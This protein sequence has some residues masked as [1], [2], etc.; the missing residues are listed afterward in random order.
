MYL[1]QFEKYKNKTSLNSFRNMSQQFRIIFEEGLQ[2]CF[3]QKNLIGKSVLNVK[4]YVEKELKFL[5][6]LISVSVNIALVPLVFELTLY[7][8]PL[9]QYLWSNF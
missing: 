6:L 5:S 8:V 1:W 4:T 2:G 9:N 7:V 3:D